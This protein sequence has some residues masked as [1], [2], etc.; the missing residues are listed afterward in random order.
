MVICLIGTRAQ[1]IKMAPILRHLETS[2]TPYRLVLSGQHQ[3]T[4]AALLE[5]FGVRTAPLV[6][7]HGPEIT[8]V[9]SLL[10]WFV[11][12]LWQ[13]VT[14]QR[15]WFRVAGGE[16]ACM[17][18]HGD[19][20]ST[21]LGALLGRWHGLSVVHVE[22]GLTSGRWRE[23]FPEELTRRVVFRLAHIAC[24]PGSAAAGYLAGRSLRVVDTGTNTIIDAVQVARERFAVVEA[25]IPATPYAVV[26]LHRFEN[27]FDRARFESLLENLTR[28]AA[29]LPLVFVLHPS[30]RRQA[31]R[32]GLMQRLETI[33]GL[34]LLP[35]MTYVPFLKLAS[36]A[37]CV[38]TDGGSNQEELAFLGVPTLLMRR[39][40]ERSDG[41]GGSVK[42][43][44][45]APG[46]LV[47]FV[48]QV[49]AMPP[50]AAVGGT[51]QERGPAAQ[52]AALLRQ[53]FGGPAAKKTI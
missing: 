3:E 24:C 51:L 5:E 22:S 23:P 43:G 19:T 9:G 13:G 20:V 32:L 21:L 34:T 25:P 49:L 36:H 44:G 12:M 39:V 30:T 28:A 41:L 16:S 27:I 1:L 53:E 46:A 7:S 26:S 38:I 40:T 47:A 10:R 33:P 35:R 48:Q 29:L 14:R 31:K 37:R 15:A 42:L 17:V 4:M 52:I 50:R 2:G 6:M 11:R 18:V 8:R 45:D